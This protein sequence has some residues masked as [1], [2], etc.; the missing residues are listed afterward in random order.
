[1]FATFKALDSGVNILNLHRSIIWGLEMN[2]LG[3]W[4]LGTKYLSWQMKL[5]RI[6]MWLTCCR[7][8]FEALYPL[9]VGFQ[10]TRLE[11]NLNGWFPW[12]CSKTGY[13]TCS[14]AYSSTSG[15][16]TPFWCICYISKVRC[17]NVLLGK[18]LLPQYTPIAKLIKCYYIAI[19]YCHN[20][21]YH[22]FE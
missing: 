13:N 2:S 15:A 22:D 7:T 1:M 20:L 6:T 17:E 12:L 11:V 21:Q 14:K 5:A 18:F 19:S 9:F 8:I 3:A 16:F 10:I 4:G